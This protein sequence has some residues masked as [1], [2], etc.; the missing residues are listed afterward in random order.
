MPY[1]QKIHMNF[2]GE[3]SCNIYIRL[4]G[5]TELKEGTPES[6]NHK[7]SKLTKLRKADRVSPFSQSG[8]DQTR[9][10][11]YCQHLWG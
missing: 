5:M 6:G 3:R 8:G 2:R 7:T 4:T 11:F 10:R 1:E 9:S